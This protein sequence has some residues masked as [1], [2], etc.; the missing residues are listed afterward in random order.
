MQFMAHFYAYFLLILIPITLNL[1][2]I[3]SNIRK[4]AM[5]VII[6]T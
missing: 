4:D 5:F 2:D 3:T 6:K 1:Q